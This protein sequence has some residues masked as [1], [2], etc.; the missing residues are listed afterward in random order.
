MRPLA[1]RLS[2]VLLLAALPLASIARA[3]RWTLFDAH[4]HY[5]DDARSPYPVASVLELL[6]AQGVTTIL[7]TSRPNEG[8][9]ALAA[10]AAADPRAPRVVPFLRPYRNQDDRQTW[11]RD[12]SILAL[13]EDELARDIGYRGIGEFHVFGS[14]AATD[15]VR[16]IARMAAAR[17][18]WLH[19]HCDEAA[20]EALFRHAPTVRVIWAHSGFSVPPERLERWLERHPTLVG[21]LSY[22]YDIT[23]DGRLADDWRALLVR[24]PGRFVLGSDTWINER[25]ARYDEIVAWYRGWLDQLPGEVATALAHGNGERLFPA[26]DPSAAPGRTIGP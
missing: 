22:R 9:R 6:R 13:I 4:L 10:A 24:Y 17:G 11:H 15:Q 5:N 3:E 25:W 16:T 26:R 23:R 19:A 7:A 14:D 12:P 18:L 20:L 1:C 8:T 2:I 21:E